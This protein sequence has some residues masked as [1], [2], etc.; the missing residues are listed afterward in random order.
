MQVEGNETEGILKD[1]TPSN[2]DGNI[3]VLEA[4]IRQ[5]FGSTSVERIIK[6]K[7]IPFIQRGTEVNCRPEPFEL[8]ILLCKRSK[9]QT[10]RSQVVKLARDKCGYADED[11]LEEDVQLVEIYGQKVRVPCL[12]LSCMWYNNKT[13][14][15]QVLLSI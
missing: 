2:V 11:L 12:I 8:T 15:Y 9:L 14:T 3:A 1:L 4:E 6:I 13:L 5:L 10:L 7:F